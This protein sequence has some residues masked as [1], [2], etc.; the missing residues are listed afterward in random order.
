MEQLNRLSRTRT[1]ST[2]P[3]V[4]KV[5]DLSPA[6]YAAAEEVNLSDLLE[7]ESTRHWAIS[8]LSNV[9]NNVHHD[10]EPDS[11]TQHDRAVLYSMHRV[12]SMVSGEQRHRSFQKCK[13]SHARSKRH[14]EANEA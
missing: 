8:F 7:M 6:A 2:S 4:D 12:N 9:I 10:S 14:Q 11:L 5:P 13:D 1:A 3:M